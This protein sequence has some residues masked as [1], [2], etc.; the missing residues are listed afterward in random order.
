MQPEPCKGHG[1]II[2]LFQTSLELAVTDWLWLATCISTGK[3]QSVPRSWKQSETGN[4]GLPTILHAAAADQVTSFQ[5]E[6]RIKCSGSHTLLPTGSTASQGY[7][8]QRGTSLVNLSQLAYGSSE[9]S[10]SWWPACC[11]PAVP[12]WQRSSST[13]HD[14]EKSHE[15]AI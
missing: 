3:Q 7:S 10:K 6:R 1:Y 8:K 15:I 2:Q 9:W 11:R 13:S 14:G 4:T 12:R 5:R